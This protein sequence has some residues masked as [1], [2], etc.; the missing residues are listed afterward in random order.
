MDSSHLVSFHYFDFNHLHLAVEMTFAPHLKSDSR[1]ALTF[2]R[3][4]EPNGPKRFPTPQ[5]TV[6]S[7]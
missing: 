4:F 2:Y 1:E 3:T 5:K 7:P 6:L